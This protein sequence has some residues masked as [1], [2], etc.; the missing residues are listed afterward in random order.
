MSATV[1]LQLGRS[2]Y[3][4]KNQFKVC[5]STYHEIQHLVTRLISVNRRLKFDSSH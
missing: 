4:K 5:R 2:G 3:K 1:T